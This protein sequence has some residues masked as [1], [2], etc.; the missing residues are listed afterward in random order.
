MSLIWVFNSSTDGLRNNAIR[1]LN[2]CLVFSGPVTN[3]LPVKSLDWFM[4]M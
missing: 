2:L 1:W 3:D 4:S